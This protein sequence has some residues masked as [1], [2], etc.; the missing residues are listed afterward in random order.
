M[1]PLGLFGR[2]RMVGCLKVLEKAIYQTYLKV[3]SVS[4]GP[5]RARGHAYHNACM[6]WGA[7]ATAISATD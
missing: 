7:V 2:G 1:I 6:R 3:K 5:P 4:G